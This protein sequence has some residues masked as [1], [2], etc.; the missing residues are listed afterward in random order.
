[1]NGFVIYS[2]A[3]GVF[4]GDC[5]GFAFWSKL[6]PVGQDCAVAFPTRKEAED[7]IALH[8][9]FDPSNVDMRAVPVLADHRG[10]ATISECVRVGLPGWA[11]NATPFRNDGT[12]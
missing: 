2:E 12:P 5:L 9:E 8:R 4:I 11:P 1:M 6:D 3:I 7:F 10:F